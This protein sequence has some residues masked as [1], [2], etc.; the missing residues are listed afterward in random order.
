MVG[1]IKLYEYNPT[2]MEHT[3]TMIYSIL[4][5]KAVRML[6]FMEEALMDVILPS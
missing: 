2:A 3:T 1:P 6:V 4:P 5:R